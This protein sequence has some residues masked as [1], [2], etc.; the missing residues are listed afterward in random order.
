MKRVQTQSFFFVSYFPV[1]GLNTG[2]H[3]PEKAPY[4]GAFQA[5]TIAQR[6]ISDLDTLKKSC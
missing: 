4:L 3:G 5:V 2:K 1:F 6:V